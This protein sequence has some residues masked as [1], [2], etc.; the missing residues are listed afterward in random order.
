MQRGTG[1][2]HMPMFQ[3]SAANI[4]IF[5]YLAPLPFYHFFFGGKELCLTQHYIYS[6]LAWVNKYNNIINQN[7]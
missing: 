1:T 2:T 5:G 3:A 6:T 7:T 4:G